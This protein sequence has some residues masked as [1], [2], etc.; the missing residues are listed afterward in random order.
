[1]QDKSILEEALTGVRYEREAVA[2]AL[3]KLGQQTLSACVAGISLEDFGGLLMGD[4]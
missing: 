3:E 1:M 4:C 2:L